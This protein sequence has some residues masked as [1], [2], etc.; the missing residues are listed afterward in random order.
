MLY[1]ESFR[2]KKFMSEDKQIPIRF[3]II[4]FTAFIMLFIAYSVVT[5][6]K[7]KQSTE[8]DKATVI[9]DAL[10]ISMTDYLETNVS[11]PEYLLAGQSAKVFIP[12][13]KLHCPYLSASS[14]DPSRIILSS[15]SHEQCKYAISIELASGK[16]LSINEQGKITHLIQN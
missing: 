14:I 16:T 9:L 12:I 10:Y 11:F 2:R 8:E 7:N 15:I 1:F 3:T 6:S 5:C 13:L 4:A